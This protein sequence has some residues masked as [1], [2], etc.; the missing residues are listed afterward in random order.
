MNLI[1][2]SVVLIHSDKLYFRV[3]FSSEFKMSSRKDL[4][5]KDKIKILDRM[6]EKPENTPVRELEKFLGVPKST[7]ARLKREETKLREDLSDVQTGKAG[8]RKRKREGKNPDVD[9]A[10]NKWFAVRSEQGVNLSGPM[11]KT[12]AEELA[13]KMGHNDFSATDGWL[14]RWKVRHNIKFK[15]HHGEKGSADVLKA[16]EWLSNQLPKLLTEY[17]LEDVYNADETGLYYRATPDGSLAYAHQ[18]LVGSKKA[19]DRITV[20]CC[21]NATGTD[22]RPLLVIGKSLQPRCFK[23]VNVNSLPVV[24]RANKNA[25][26]T[27]SIFLPWLKIWNSE[28]QKEGRKILLLIDNATCHP[29]VTDFGNIT[30]EFL[31]ANTTSLIQ[32]LDKGI[33]KNLKVH[34]R[35]ML[36]GY[37]LQLIEEDPNFKSSTAK[38]ISSKVNVLQAIQFVADSW[39]AVTTRTIQNCFAR[40]GLHLPAGIENV[41]AEEDEEVTII[42]GVKNFEEFL[43]VDDELPCCDINENCE[44][45]IIEQV[46]KKNRPNEEESDDDDE[47]PTM[48][49]STTEAKRCMEN[50]RLFFM[51]QGNEE[52]PIEALNLCSDFLHKQSM[53][54]L[55]QR[56][57]DSYLLPNVRD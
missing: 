25:W 46:L 45:E 27:T 50:V 55:Q 42:Q 35:G 49:V 14:S 43:S 57:L 1:S 15:K 23:N 11:L 40:C 13:V 32:P 29:T 26:M 7:I 22:K 10:L 38:E 30:V 51:Q 36:V 28:L 24:Y 53:R 21:C 41:Q 2:C 34:Y 54:N 52:S 3:H 17:S 39:R 12:K 16:E 31:P 19:M 8:K 37:I 5:L 47:V 44:D 6:K 33:I 48:R 20:L 4:S 9:D 56:R 18:S